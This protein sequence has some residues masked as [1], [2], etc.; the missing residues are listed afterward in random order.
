[1]RIAFKILKEYQGGRTGT[2]AVIPKIRKENREDGPKDNDCRDAFNA[3]DNRV[4]E[5]VVC[6]DN[7]PGLLMTNPE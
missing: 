7:S 1:M 2:P 3:S 4:I 5:P 6:N